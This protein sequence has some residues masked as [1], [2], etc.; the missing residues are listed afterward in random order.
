MAALFNNPPGEPLGAAYGSLFFMS[1]WVIF[2]N[3][4]FFP[5]WICELPHGL[6][7]LGLLK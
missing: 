2:A 3:W 6:A 5:T 4:I 7:D 1:G